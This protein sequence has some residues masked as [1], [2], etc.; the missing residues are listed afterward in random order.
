MPS[1]LRRAPRNHAGA[2]D[3]R[4]RVVIEGVR[5]EVDCG[6]FPV[7]RTVGESVR[8]TASIHADGHDVLAAV[9]RYRTAPAGGTRGEWRE[10]P[11]P[12]LGNDEWTAGFEVEQQCAHEYTVDTPAVIDALAG[13]E[14]CRALLEAMFRE[15][16]IAMRH[17]AA[18]ATAQGPATDARRWPI[19]RSA[20]EQSHSCVIFGN[21]YILKLLRRLEPGPNPDL[22]IS[23]FLSS[24]GFAGIPPPAANLGYDRPGDGPTALA[25]VQ[26]FV[27]N[28]GTGY[29][30]ANRPQWVSIP[31]LGILQILNAPDAGMDFR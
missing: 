20:A 8:V 21:R 5:P 1:P 22:E 30:L 24:R 6:R 9:L 10:R 29:E 13:D 7:K 12:P 25:L 23:R 3:G 15:H 18:R 28:E 27:A 19:V 26:T 16:R 4:R 2:I 31:L 17:G 11:M 14:A